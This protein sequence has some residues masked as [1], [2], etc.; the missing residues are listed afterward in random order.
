MQTNWK[1]DEL[2]FHFW[3]SSILLERLLS[4]L[5]FNTSDSENSSDILIT[6]DH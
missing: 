1:N 4:K 6:F 3:S 2:K 5:D